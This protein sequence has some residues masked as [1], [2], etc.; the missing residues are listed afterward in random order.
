MKRPLVALLGLAVAL[1]G[2]GQTC[3]RVVQEGSHDGLADCAVWCADGNGPWQTDAGGQV[4]I[5]T[6]C[7]SVRIEKAGYPV[8]WAS[9]VVAEAKGTV[10]VGYAASTLLKEVVIEHWPRKR[11]RQALAATGTLDSTLI[12]GFERASLRSAAQW[13]PGVQW[14]ERGHGGSTRLS[15]RGS[16]LRSPYGVRGVKVYWGPFPL[17]LADGSTPLEMLDPLLVGSLD[18][19]RSVGSPMYGSAPSGLLLAGGPFRSAVGTD[20]TVEAT[21]GSC[22]YY[23]LGAVARTNKDGR[24]FTAGLVHQRNDGY[25]DQESNARDQAFI[26]SSFALKKSVTRVFVT[27]QKASWELPGSVDE[28]TAEED[29]RAARAYSVL[30]DAHIDKEQVMGGLANELRL[31]ENIT[32]RGGMHGQLIDKTNPYGTTAANCGY[33]EET[34]RAFGA[35]LS[36]GGTRSFKL[37]IAW[38]IG[39]EALTERDRLR[40]QS[41]VDR[42]IGDVK[43]NGDTRVVNLN[44]FATT[45]TR[46]GRKLTLHA[47]VGMERTDYDHTDWVAGTQKKLSTT[48]RALPYAGLEQVIGS[49]YKLHLRYAESMSRATVWEFLGSSGRFNSTLRGEHVREWELGASNELAETPVRAD[50]TVFH[51]LV[52]DLITQKQISEGRTYYENQDQ[53][54]VAGCELL[55][56]GPVH[57][58]GAQR[59][60][61]LASTAITTTDLRR[62]DPTAGS[63]SMGD[64]PGIPLITAG[65]VARASGFLSKGL[66]LEAGVRLIGSTPTGGPATTDKHME[67]AR[68]S[69]LLAGRATDISL[70]VHCENLFDA[71]YSSWIQVNDPGGRYYN[72]APGR[73]LFFGIRLIF[74]SRSAGRAD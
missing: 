8:T 5:P 71:R 42:R 2:S 37:P 6:R 74:G 17:T 55:V 12:A 30:L 24:L 59:V 60:D 67:H 3:F 58:A 70:F 13:I 40:E 7:D 32:V 10:E 4:C 41:Y 56:R 23:R 46:L 19:V 66:G 26:A 21:G 63:E 35:R 29:P 51:R 18:I 73:S 52:E 62:T 31:G 50:F 61:L 47:G 14:D 45:V 16:L 1:A 69:Y 53:A 34:I 48:P 9:V 28:R 39:L 64:I 22:G 65:L 25:R 43:V 38:D 33:K 68:L 49:G 54:L 15:I 20:A 36:I 57:Q 11:D 27:W 72:P 44:T